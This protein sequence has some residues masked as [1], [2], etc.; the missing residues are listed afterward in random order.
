[1][2]DSPIKIIVTTGYIL[3]LSDYG[4]RYPEAVPLRNIDA[5]HVAEELV[6]VFTRVGIPSEI[7]TD[8]ST[9]VLSHKEARSKQ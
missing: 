8:Q 1:M 6:R 5:E 2:S 4:T 7:L 9:A 3:V